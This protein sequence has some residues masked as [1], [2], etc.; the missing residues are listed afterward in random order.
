MPFGAD[1]KADG[2]PTLGPLGSPEPLPQEPSQ[3]QYHDNRLGVGVSGSTVPPTEW[4]R[5]GCILE[6]WSLSPLAM[7]EPACTPTAHPQGGRHAGDLIPVLWPCP[8]LLDSGREAGRKDV[9][10]QSDTHSSCVAGNVPTSLFQS[11]HLECSDFPF[12]SCHLERSHS[13]PLVFTS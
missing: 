9:P 2:A 1:G 8:P 3:L 12:Q 5:E 7:S 4:P 6:T 13:D 10:V 11:C